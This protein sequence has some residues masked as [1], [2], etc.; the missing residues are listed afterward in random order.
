MHK[1]ET[2]KK[3]FLAFAAAATLGGGMLPAGM[4]LAQPAAQA[5][6]EYVLSPEDVIEVTVRN[7][8]D[9]NKAGAILPNGRFTYP[10]IG[11]ITAAGK[12][13]A[14][15]A[16]EIQKAVDR[17]RN[18]AVVVVSIVQFH[19]MKV[20]VIGSA[21]TKPGQY[22][23]RSNYRLLDL[24]ALAGGVTSKPHL[25]TGRLLRPNGQTVP[26]HFAKAM[27]Q[28][29]GDANLK[30]SVNDV[31]LLDQ[32]DP[33]TNKVYVTGQVVNPSAFDLLEGTNLRSLVLAAGG[34]T[35][36]AGMAAAYVIRGDKQVPVDL[37]PSLIE[38]QPDAA[39]TGFQLQAGDVL[40]IPK[41]TGRY[42]V[43]GSVSQSRYFLMPEKQQVTV[44]DA[45]Q[46]A[47]PSSQADLAKAVLMRQTAPGKS[48]E[49]IPINIEQMFKKDKNGNPLAQ[50]VLLKPEDVVY[51]PTKSQS[52][53]GALQQGLSI[54]S[55]LGILGFRFFK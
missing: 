32:V 49:L 25:T 40:H 22:D 14:Q 19:P 16:A 45:I 24:V 52:S 9:L 35:K 17:T 39:V 34:E 3:L 54:A 6:D 26:I 47:V 42:G 36:E 23:L 53:G 4:A 1:V 11:E 50:N 28:P 12:T 37:R 21:V 31:V 55:V 20:S 5:A 29:D 38:G 44:L 18:Q 46:S 27:A 48:P 8:P 2:M 41:V 30:V 43:L 51:I 7:H 33:S 13:P 10:E 15:L